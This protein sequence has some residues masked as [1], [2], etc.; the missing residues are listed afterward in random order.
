M[1]FQDFFCCYPVLSPLVTLGVSPVFSKTR[2][3]RD[4]GCQRV[5]MGDARESLLTAPNYNTPVKDLEY[6]DLLTSNFTLAS[7]ERGIKTW[8]VPATYPECVIF[9][10]RY[11]YESFNVECH[12]HPNIGKA[13]G[14]E[15]TVAPCK[16]SL[17]TSCGPHRKRFLEV[18]TEKHF[19][20][21]SGCTDKTQ[22]HVGWRLCRHS[23]ASRC[24][25]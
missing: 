23:F 20:S 13:T 25:R 9:S 18:Q 1:G 12:M 2:S 8:C 22:P 17:P 3:S 11:R 24:R 6:N 19:A 5:P 4:G 14:R 15:R 10:K 21:R 16:E 7:H